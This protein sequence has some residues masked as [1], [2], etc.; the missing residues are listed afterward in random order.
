MTLAWINVEVEILEEFALAHRMVPREEVAPTLPEARR[1]AY[2]VNHEVRGL[3]RSCARPAARG[4]KS[5]AVHLTQ[6]A[7]RA[8]RS[9]HARGT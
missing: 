4:R 9:N 7:A 1:A 3:C 5:C 8:R 2:H 6:N